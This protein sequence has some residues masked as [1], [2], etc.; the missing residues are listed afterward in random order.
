MR[1]SYIAYD[2]FYFE[3]AW[4]KPVLGYCSLYIICYL[5][6]KYTRYTCS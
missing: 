6:Q 1:I 5:L 2:E 3:C 4:L